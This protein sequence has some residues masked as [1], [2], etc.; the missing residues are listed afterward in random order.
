MVDFVADMYEGTEAADCAL[1]C[2]MRGI[3]EP[4]RERCEAE[5]CDERWLLADDGRCRLA[6]KCSSELFL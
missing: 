5:G 1:L 6:L 3:A 4:G 2:C